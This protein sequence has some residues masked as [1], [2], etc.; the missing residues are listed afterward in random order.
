MTGSHQSSEERAST[1]M[2]KDTKMQSAAQRNLRMQHRLHKI[3]KTLHRTAEVQTH[4][5]MQQLCIH[6]TFCVGLQAQKNTASAYKNIPSDKQYTE[7][8]RGFL[9]DSKKSQQH[10]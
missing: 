4:V 6:W 1:V 5:G 7:E 10:Q 8:N 9:E 2:K 3:N